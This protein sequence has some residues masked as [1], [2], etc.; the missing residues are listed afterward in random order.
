V[1]ARVI[2]QT[3]GNLLRVAVA[4]HAGFD[5]VIAEAE[6]VWSTALDNQFARRVA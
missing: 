1:P 2:G 4:G 3:G 6:R 5:V